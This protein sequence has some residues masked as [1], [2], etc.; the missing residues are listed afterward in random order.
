MTTHEEAGT[1]APFDPADPGH[2]ADP[3]PYAAAARKTCPVSQPRD[4]VFVITRFDDSLDVLLDTDTFSNFGNFQLDRDAQPPAG[5]GLIT[6]LDP[7]AH[8]ALRNHLLTMFAPRKL[9]QHEDRVREIVRDVLSG[10]SAG[11]EIELFADI[12]RPVTS[13]TVYAFLGFPEDDWDR[14]KGWGDAVNEVLPEPFDS[15]PEF[16]SLIGYLIELARER[17]AS[18]PTGA[19]VLDTLLHSPPEGAPELEPEAA[20]VH[21]MQLVFAGTDTTA[22]LITNLC[23]ELLHDRR[24]WERVCGDPNL[25]NA[26]IEE[27]LR[28]DSPLQMIMRT[29]TEATEVRGCPIAAGD[30]IILSLQS[31]NWDESTWEP[32]AETF[33]LDRDS[34]HGHLAMGR[35]I[36]TCLGAPLARLQCRL[37]IEEMLARFPDLRLQDGYEYR[38]AP[39]V[40][41]R[42]PTSLPVR[43]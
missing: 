12:A 13:R 34:E 43:L 8:T 24:N 14:I 40:L 19:D 15:V 26:A 7:P 18:P 1:Q 28:H 17:K 2:H 35:G 36:H 27:S 39:G 29:A 9:R 10:F 25:I 31:A 11:D 16:H 30:K 21:A 38:V 23:Y 3:A 42:R 5:V 6:Q 33:S 37:V 41:V 4:G 20:A 32:D 22:S